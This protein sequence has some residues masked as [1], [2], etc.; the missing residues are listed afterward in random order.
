MA[1]TNRDRVGKALELLQSGLIPYIQREMEAEYKGQWLRQAGYSLRNFDEN[2]PHWDAHALLLLLWEQW[3]SVFGRTLGHSERSIVSELREV[4]NAWA[5]QKP[6]S[7][8][9]AY[10]ALD[11]MARLLT[12][13]S[14]PEAREL[15]NQKQDLLRLRFA[16]QERNERRKVSAAPIEGQPQGGLLPWREIVTPHPDVASGRYL[17]AEFAADLAS[18]HRGDVGA[19]SEYTDPR[20][21]FRRTY[22]TDGLRGLLATAIRRLS[23]AGGD[24]VV[25]LQTNF[26]GGKTH[27]MLALFHLVSGARAGELPGVESILDQLE[28][29]A[30][31]GARVAVLV[32]TALS[33][34]QPNSKPDGIRTKTLWGEMAW[35]LG[36]A[37]GYALLAQSDEMGVNPGSNLLHEL[38][39]RFGPCLILIDEWVT[40][41]RQLYNKE[42]NL[43]AGSFDANLSFAQ[44]LTEAVKQAPRTLLVAA[45][46]SSD[47]EIGGEGGRQALARLQNTF[48]RTESSWRPASAEESFEIVRRRLFQPIDDPRKFAARDAVVGIFAR[49][50]RDQPQEFPPNCREA[51]YERR[52]QA[53]YPIHPELFDRLYND[54]STLEKFQRTRGVLRLMAAVIHALWERNDA[55]LLI[56]PASLPMDDGPV[57]AELIRYMEDHWAPVIEK[58]VDGPASLPLALDREHPNLGRYSATRRVARTIYLGSAPTVRTANPGLDE[59][60]IKLGCAQPGETVATFGDALRRLSDNATHLYVNRNRYWFS[61]QPSVTRLAQDRTGQIANDIEVVWEEIRRRLRLDRSRGELAGVHWVPASSADVPDEMSVRLVILDPRFAHALRDETSDARREAQ[62]Y[63][64]QRGNGPRLY[65]NMLV[66]LAPDRS[67]LV[68]LQ[69]AVAQYLAWKSIHDERESLN[70]DSFQRNQAGTRT[71]QADETVDARIRE[72]YIWLLV[73][74]QNDPRDPHSLAWSESRLQG[75]ES[76]AVRAS[77]KLVSNE[78]LVTTFAPLRLV[79]EMDRFNLWQGREH[80]GLQQLWEYFARYPYLA[81][82]RDQNVLL[83]C[84]RS[85]V[86]L[87]TWQENFAFAGGWDGERKRYLNLAAG[88]PVGQIALD[89]HCLLVHPAAAR[90]QLDADQAAAQ[91]QPSPAPGGDTGPGRQGGMSEGH[92]P[93]SAPQPRP[94]PREKKLRRFYGSVALNPM[95]LGRDAGTIGEEILQ[96]LSSLMGA[97]VQITLEIQARL[98]EGAPDGVVRTV[99][100]NARTLRFENFGFEEE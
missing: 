16:E 75:P 18:V 67:R 49:Y 28:I 12:A 19:S 45:L 7:T 95:R 72:T 99:S 29:N 52:M 92:Q 37:E 83:E 22:L 77:R 85:G 20:E 63:F 35:Q 69:E 5:H 88:A 73:P 36:G 66:F 61:T 54:W 1:L 14:A 25:E 70:L 55:G 71:E 56:L 60:N 80:I 39:T 46:P 91:P 87:I 51:D 26:G 97:D 65:Q 58:D 11:S 53:A 47:I 9:D 6:F 74:G 38:F 33:P 93:G 30:A 27:S 41:L 15:E 3:N 50:Y 78:Q 32:G 81:R 84:V 21:F 40:F 24:P 100:E 23:G 82:L 79:M 89:A 8:D 76:L 13:I 42:E 68:E 31:P 86:A 57:Q 10:R 62:V 98:P 90:R 2:D 34:G 64:T 43:P 59:R 17:Q 4:R 96:H 48:S 44:S 94:A